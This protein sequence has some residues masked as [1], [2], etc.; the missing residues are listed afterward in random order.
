VKSGYRLVL[1]YNLIRTDYQGPGSANAISDEKASLRSV[2]KEWKR[3]YKAGQPTSEKLLYILDHKYS[4]ANL[5]LESLKG[6]DVIL[7]RILKESCD[8]EDFLLLFANM[9]KTILDAQ[10]TNDGY[11]DPSEEE[12]H[13]EN[14]VKATGESF[15]R[16][17]KMSEDEIVQCSPHDRMPDEITSKETGNEGVDATH[18]YH[19]AVS[20]AVLKLN[21]HGLT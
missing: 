12:F 6:R 17:A 21:Y 14:L 2:L 10:A 8:K 16:E 4:E 20:Y 11:G 18:F 7:G 13:L 15:L 5:C 9:T 3:R 19:D 1:T